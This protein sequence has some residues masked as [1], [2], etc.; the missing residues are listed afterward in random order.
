M[1]PEIVVILAPMLTRASFHV[2]EPE[3]KYHGEI[4]SLRL[5]RECGWL[6]GDFGLFGRYAIEE[7]YDMAFAYTYNDKMPIERERWEYAVREAWMYKWREIQE[8]ETG[9]P[10][11]VEMTG[12]NPE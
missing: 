11:P 12:G 1:R 10:D 5:A 7:T 4:G 6:L 2:V 8:E 3:G 9:S